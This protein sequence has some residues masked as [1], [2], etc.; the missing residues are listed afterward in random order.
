MIR[1]RSE[2]RLYR[3]SPGRQYG[4]DYNPLH[5]QSLN[6][7]EQQ[8]RPYAS[9]QSESWSMREETSG[10]TARNTSGPLT[11]RPNPRRTRQLLRQNIIASK[12]KSVPLDDTGQ[13]DPELRGRYAHQDEDQEVYESEV[14]STLYTNRHPRSAQLVPPAQERYIDVEEDYDEYSEYDDDQWE[15]EEPQYIDPDLGYDYEREED[16]HV[17]RLP[18]TE[19]PRAKSAGLRVQPET[20]ERGRRGSTPLDYDY[21][22]DEQDHIATERKKKKKGISRR[23][24]LV[25]AAVVGV[26]GTAIAA[27]ELA[28][29]IPQA[30][31]Q[32]GTNIE[33][34]LQDAFNKGVAAGEEAVRKEFINAL[35]TLEGV[36]LEGAIGAAKLTRVAYDVFVSPLVTLAAT[37]ADDF[38]SVTLGAIIKARSWLA[39]INADNATLAAL[40]AVLQNWVNQ[41]HNMPK[42]LKTI[43]ETDL[44]GA[45]AYLR[46]LRRKIKEEQAKLNG[47]STA[48]TPAPTSTPKGK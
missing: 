17:H 21:D 6:G 19:S 18:Y 8:R 28:P 4:Y 36:T 3:K 27:Y 13:L 42:K 2:R 45:Q 41:A 44:D 47:Q 11:S 46:A 16:P 1:D 37:V 24:L 40:Q 31:E 39:Q 34:Q 26:G 33:H 15:D 12:S 5:S 20:S 9:V 23:K 14:D 7:D 25:G 38:L 43:T 32:A 10:R 48:P 35:D 30:L 22:A 29:K